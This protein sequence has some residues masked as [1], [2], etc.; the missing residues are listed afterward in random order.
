M[1]ITW[2]IEGQVFQGTHNYEVKLLRQ[3]VI[4]SEESQIPGSCCRLFSEYPDSCNSLSQSIVCP[5]ACH[6][7]NG[8]RNGLAKHPIHDFE[9]HAQAKCKKAGHWA[10]ELLGLPR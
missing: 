10:R 7:L 4:V 2:G 5:S 1:E 3:F 9:P 8:P 6:L